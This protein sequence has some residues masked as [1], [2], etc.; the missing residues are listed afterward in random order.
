MEM[1]SVPSS[2]K[3]KKSVKSLHKCEYVLWSS[4]G[5]GGA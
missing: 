4:L 3:K 2:F 5:G 1:T